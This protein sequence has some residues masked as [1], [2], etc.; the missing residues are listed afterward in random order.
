MYIINLYKQQPTLYSAENNKKHPT[1]M[2]I[3]TQIF[4]L[5]ICIQTSYDQNVQLILKSYIPVV[6]STTLNDK[7]VITLQR[8]ATVQTS[9][10]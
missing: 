6:Y 4:L 8:V 1:I 7:F 3:F 10:N 2:M 5:E 9:T